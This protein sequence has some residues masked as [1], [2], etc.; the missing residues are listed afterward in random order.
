MIK[1]HGFMKYLKNTSWLISE[2]IIRIIST[3]LVGVW[4]VRY[5]GPSDYGL[6]KYAQSYVALFAVLSTFGVD[7]IVIRELV[8]DNSKRDKLIGTVFCIK[9]IG[10]FLVLVILAIAIYF[11]SN[12]PLTNSIVF[13]IASSTIFQSFNIVDLYF[14]SKVMGKYVAYSN[15]ISLLL[16]SFSK[17]GLILYEAP[18]IAFAWIVLFESFILAMGLIYFYIKTSSTFYIKNYKFNKKIAISLLKD[19]WPLFLSAIVVTVY[20]KIDQVMIK[21]MLN[22]DAVGQYAAAVNLS[23]AWYF[24]PM[25]I[26]ASVFPAIINAKKKSE[27][28]YYTRIQKLYNLMVFLALVVALPMTFLSDWIV[29]LLYGVEYSQSGSI[30]MIHTW[31][32][33]F[34]FLGVASAQW[35]VVENL[36]MLSFWRTFIGMVV[37]IGFNYILIPKY[38]GIGAAYATIIAQSI[39]SFFYDIFHK[40]TR[41][42]FK[43]KLKALNIYMTIK[44]LKSFKIEKF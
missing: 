43:M 31:A 32:G 8:K 21:E 30:L 44:S 25:A 20:M 4:V 19:S 2:K 36:L 12:N 39:A 22:V 16:I 17:I 27:E 33:V 24:I 1:N 11:T 18:I 13:I 41:I 23:E 26:V 42:M 38:G 35:F 15:M 14:Q 37:N 28:L 6:L 3:I 34:V 40:D 5:L 10:A 29:A 9:L 7:S